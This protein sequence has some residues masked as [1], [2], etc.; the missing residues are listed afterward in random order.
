MCG[1]LNHRKKMKAEASRLTLRKV[2][3]FNEV[4]HLRNYLFCAKFDRN[5]KSF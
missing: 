2:E 3:T 1:N 4:L 5:A